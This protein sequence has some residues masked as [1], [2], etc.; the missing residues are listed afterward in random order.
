M[1]IVKEIRIGF[2]NNLTDINVEVGYMDP[3]GGATGK[4]F[5]IKKTEFWQLM[6]KSE[7]IDLLNRLW[8]D[9]WDQ[10][11]EFSRKKREKREGRQSK[12]I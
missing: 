2:Q 1:Y 5:S 10:I 6:S 12:C 9:R 11:D 7:V 4:D 3:E 8:M